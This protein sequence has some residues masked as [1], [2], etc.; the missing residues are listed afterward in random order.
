[1]TSYKQKAID[2]AR[3]TK[4]DIERWFLKRLHRSGMFRDWLRWR[5]HTSIRSRGPLRVIVGGG[6]YLPYR[7]WRLTDQDILDI[8]VESH[9]QALFGE[10]RIDNLL[11]EHVWEH[12]TWEEGLC[13]AEF[14]FRYLRSGGTLR[15]AVPDGLHP[16]RLYIDAV[17]P[18]GTGSA[19]LDHKV[20]LT[21]AS[22]RQML[23][24]A[25]FEVTVLEY[26]DENGCFHHR[27]FSYRNGGRIN[28]R[29]VFKCEEPPWVR[30]P[31]YADRNEHSGGKEDRY[32]FNY[33]S[34]IVDARKPIERHDAAGERLSA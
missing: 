4:R 1:M 5:L 26:W 32:P 9:W 31:E 21:H 27:P 19:A 11:A 8:A 15:I 16:H 29:P 25:G 7:G 20:L 23:E 6:H 2:F 18:G 3:Y 12:L 30:G 14:S 33:T 34:L 17:K 28:R 10:R 24:R 22:L 13:A